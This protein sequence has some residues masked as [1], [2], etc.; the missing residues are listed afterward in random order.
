VAPCARCGTFLCGACTELVKEAAW[1]ADCV[2][3]LR[4]NAPT[5]RAVHI[6]IALGVLGFLCVLPCAPLAPVYQLVMGVLGLW[7]PTR[8][9]RRIQRGEGPARG[10]WQAHAARIIGG[11]NLVQALAWAAYLLLYPR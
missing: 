8:E 5:S 10:A 6:L 2:A 3:W 1:C 4:Q 7:L 9:L 11:L